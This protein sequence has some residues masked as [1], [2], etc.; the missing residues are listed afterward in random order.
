MLYLTTE[1]ILSTVRVLVCPKGPFGALL[2]YIRIMIDLPLGIGFFYRRLT[3]RR[4]VWAFIAFHI[5]RAVSVVQ[6]DYQGVRLNDLKSQANQTEITLQTLE[7]DTAN[8]NS[9]RHLQDYAASHGLVPA[10]PVL[11]R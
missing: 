7:V 2:V 10:N 4:L 8:A 6:A 11:S 1:Q 3:I 5:I 9:L